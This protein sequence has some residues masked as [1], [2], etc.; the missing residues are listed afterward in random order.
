MDDEPRYWPQYCEENVWHA[1]GALDSDVLE[2]Y[3]VFVSNPAHI[4]A[5]WEQRAAP[6][7]QPALWDYHVVLLM[8]RASGWSVADSDSRLGT[9]TAADVWLRQS[10]PPLPASASQYR[11]GFRLVGAAAY[12]EALRSDRSHMRVGST[13]LSPPPPWPA[14][15]EGTNL[16]RFIDMQADFLGEVLEL[17]GLRARISA[18]AD[19]PS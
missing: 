5:V 13:W 3:A 16:M 4:V 17:E 19:C 9:E 6:K 2:A 15:G 18:A 12:R 7:G 14:I 1:C 8:R 10:F 11:P